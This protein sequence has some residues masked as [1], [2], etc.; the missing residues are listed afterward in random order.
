[1]LDLISLKLQTTISAFQFSFVVEHSGAATLL[2]GQLRVII[3]NNFNREI[4]VAKTANQP[5]AHA[6]FNY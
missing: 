2:F 3:P 6:K 5:C 1:M 4:S